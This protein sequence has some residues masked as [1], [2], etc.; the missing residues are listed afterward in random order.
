M[1]NNEQN[2]FERLASLFHQEKTVDKDTQITRETSGVVE[3]TDFFAVKRIFDAKDLVGQASKVTPPEEAWNIVKSRIKRKHHFSN[4]GLW[5]FAAAVIGII[6]TIG[7]FAG[8]DIRSYFLDSEKFIAIVSPNGEVK[9]LTLADGTDVWLNSGSVLKYS[10]RFGKANRHVIVEGEALFEVAKD[11]NN[12]FTV[13]LGNSKVIVLGTKFNVKAY[14]TDDICEV[15]LVEGS[16]EYVNSQ[17]NIFIEPGERI[18]EVGGSKNLVVDKVDTEKYILWTNRTANFDSKTLLDLVSVL[19]QWYGIEFEF[20]NED[21]KSYT[22]TGRIN[23]EHTLDYTLKIIE[24]TNKVKFVKKGG[25]ILIT[26]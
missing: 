15:V 18:R 14:L 9:N 21:A 5:R 8:H 23:Q 4:T 17:K 3:D 2:K 26:N 7:W 13:S 24:M 10:N 6:L 16:I 12:P 20:A 19:E 11:S 25:K 1:N 22:F